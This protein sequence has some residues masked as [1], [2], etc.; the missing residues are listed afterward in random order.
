MD[1]LEQTGGTPTQ[2]TVT[3]NRI[4]APKHV[5]IFAPSPDAP[6][7]E[8][9][10]P[11]QAPTS[12]EDA[13]DASAS[14]A[15]AAADSLRPLPI[16]DALAERPATGLSPLAKMAVA[17]LGLVG[18]IGGL[19]VWGAQSPTTVG[20]DAVQNDVLAAPLPRPAPPRPVAAPAASA[21]IVFAD[22]LPPQVDLPAQVAP[23]VASENT[24]RLPIEA[25]QPTVA[26]RASAGGLAAAPRPAASVPT[27]DAA[28]APLRGQ[29]FLDQVTLGTVAALRGQERS[30]LPSAA[31]TALMGFVRVLADE[32]RSI[33]EI[34]A[35]L[36]EARA[37]GSLDVPGHFLRPDGRIDP[38]SVLTAL[39]H[40]N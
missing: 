32:G 23:Q 12:G 21:P 17:G 10:S 40:W 33:S 31:E 5:R 8:V 38:V 18:V 19:L 28:P 25:V 15:R 20:T 13:A 7:G 2:K 36:E 1:G 4:V 27:Q 14:H 30:E 16:D 9:A 6:G 34:A 37:G 11:E 39:E 35:M 26:P 24:V 22:P 29:N 3:L